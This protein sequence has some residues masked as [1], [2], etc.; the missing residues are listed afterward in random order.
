MLLKY[1]KVVGSVYLLKSDS[2]ADTTFAMI[3]TTRSLSGG[4]ILYLERYL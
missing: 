4:I 3:I 1:L 2:V